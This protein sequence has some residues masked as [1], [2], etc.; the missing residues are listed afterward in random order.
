MS[1]TNGL[2]SPP[3]SSDKKEED[4]EVPSCRG[5]RDGKRLGQQEE[6]SSFL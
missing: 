1:E 3:A 2:L 4:R 6:E 5:V